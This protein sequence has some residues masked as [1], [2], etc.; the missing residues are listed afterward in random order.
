M[1]NVPPIFGGVGFK[2]MPYYD[3]GAEAY[4][5]ITGKV[6]YNPIGAGIV[7]MYRPQASY[8]PS[9]DYE[10]GSIWWRSQ[11]IPTSVELT[12]LEMPEDLAEILGPINVQAVVR[13][14]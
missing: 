1:P 5:P 8:G 4:S 14:S 12:E 10:N 3:R 9:G 13:T 11:L 2:W 6:L 7:A